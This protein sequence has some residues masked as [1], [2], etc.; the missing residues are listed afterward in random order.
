MLGVEQI[1]GMK[2]I[3]VIGIGGRTGA[4]FAFELKN[5]ADVSGVGKENEV[6]IIEEKK[7]YVKRGGGSPKLLE[8][9]AIKDAEFC[10]SV[11]LPE[12]IFLT[13]KNPVG[14]A[15]EYYYKEF[16]TQEKLPALILSQNG[17][18]A[19]HEAKDA[20]EKILGEKAKEAQIIRISLLNAVEKKSLEEKIC[21][22]Y[23][24]PIRLSFSVFSGKRETSLLAGLFKEAGIEAEEIPPE[25]VRDMEFSKLF[26]NLIGISPASRD[27]SLE[28]GFKD[29]KTFK[30]EI[31]GLR[32]YIR[33]VRAAGGNFLNLSHLP[34]KL[35]AFLVEKTPLPILIFFRGKIWEII[36]KGR[37]GKKKGNL[38]EIDYYQGEVVRLGKKFGVKTPV[39]EEILKRVKERM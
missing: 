2:K 36:N 23:S 3:T 31:I 29:K 27:L 14:P 20:L 5:A 7:V 10:R 12:I 34:I 15:V 18:T 26:V 39:N 4:M 17:L 19:G 21:I 33:V 37:D 32:E 35:F 16:K 24:P 6:R 22:N 1:K 25:G 38:D 13:T 11:V 9:K 8:V 30:E 28:E